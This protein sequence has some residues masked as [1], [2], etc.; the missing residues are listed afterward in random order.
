M[1]EKIELKGYVLYQELRELVDLP[2]GYHRSL[3][4]FETKKVGSVLFV[5]VSTIKDP[6]LQAAAAVCTNL[7]YYSPLK[8]LLLT[9]APESETRRNELKQE[10]FSEGLIMHLCNSSFAQIGLNAAAL[11]EDKNCVI[12]ILDLEKDDVDDYEVIVNVNQSI[13]FCKWS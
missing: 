5:K 9:A 6:V 4:R 7:D 2:E 3:E 10:L 12:N 11:F 13:C 8:E 1:C